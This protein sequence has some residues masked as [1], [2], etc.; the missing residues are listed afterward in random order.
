MSDHIN[1]DNCSFPKKYLYDIDNFVWASFDKYD[2]MDKN[3]IFQS[4]D[5]VT[6]GITPI[7]SYI[8]GKISKIKIKSKNEHIGKGKRLGTIESL[9]YFGVIR[10]PISGTILDIN[11]NLYENPK[12]INDSPFEKGWIARIVLENPNEIQYLK[13]IDE[14]KDD[15]LDLVNKFNVKCFKI[16]PDHELYE[17]GIECSATLAKLDDYINK[18]M[19][20]GE[21]IHLVSDDPTSDLELIR[22]T[23]EKKQHLV[24]I[25]TEKYLSKLDNKKKYLF[26]ILI[27]KMH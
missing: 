18:R 7:L 24:E 12:E 21:I 9:K 19:E 1:L 16:F 25:Q 14:C 6:I 2:P 20:I 4:N 15:I 11:S 23:D 17:I 10:S 27:K 3:P 22:W 26:H 8:A 13:T 5:I